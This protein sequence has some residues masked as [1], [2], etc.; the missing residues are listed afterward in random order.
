MTLA[1]SGCGYNRLQAQDDAVGAR[2][3]ALLTQYR[4]RAAQAAELEQMVARFQ[5]RRDATSGDLAQAR[6][7]IAAMHAGVALPDDSVAFRRFEAAQRAL[8]SALDR[9]LARSSRVPGLA[10]DT[11]F[12]ALRASILSGDAQL[13][14]ARRGYDAAVQ[15]YNASVTRFSDRF[16]AR[17]FGFARKP[18]LEIEA[19][20]AER[21]D[22]DA[23]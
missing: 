22:H 13:A 11:R 9:L 20:H 18:G 2:W 8:G 23:R 7:R 5:A 12:H 17:T 3:T 10:A 19:V 15:S 6:A 21:G 16:T 1:V 14:A 4:Q